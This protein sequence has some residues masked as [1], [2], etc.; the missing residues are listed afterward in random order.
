LLERIGILF[1]GSAA[2]KEKKKGTAALGSALRSMLKS[3]SSSNYRHLSTIPSTVVETFSCG[4][5]RFALTKI[6][7]K[8]Y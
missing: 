8:Y 6:Y 1:G 2:D 5:Y 7:K 3:L 4:N